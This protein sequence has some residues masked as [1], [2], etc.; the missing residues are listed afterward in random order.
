MLLEDVAE[1]ISLRCRNNLRMRRNSL[2]LST[3][4]LRVCCTTY[5]R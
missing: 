1:Y 3:T 5:E 2:M 4:L